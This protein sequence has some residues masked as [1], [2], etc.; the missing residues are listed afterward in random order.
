MNLQRLFWTSRVVGFAHVSDRGRL[1]DA[2]LG[3]EVSQYS[4]GVHYLLNVGNPGYHDSGQTAPYRSNEI[5]VDQL[6]VDTHK[7]LGASVTHVG[8][9]VSDIISRLVLPRIVNGVLKV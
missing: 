3:F 7:H 8:Y 2:S 9:G 1:D 4:V 5:S 6:D